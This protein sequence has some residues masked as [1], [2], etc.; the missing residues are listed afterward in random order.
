MRSF[1]TRENNSSI[2]GALVPTLEILKDSDFDLILVET[3]GVGQSESEIID[4]CDFNMY[5]MTAEFGAPTQ[6]EKISM[7]DYA[8]IVVLNK[9]EKPGSDDALSMVKK[10]FQRNHNLFHEPVENMPVYATIAGRFKRS[11][12]YRTVSDSAQDSPE[13]GKRRT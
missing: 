13:P 1:A 11:R 12:R 5:V 9:S 4:I 8:N 7:L 2:S 3:T 10:Q 6:L